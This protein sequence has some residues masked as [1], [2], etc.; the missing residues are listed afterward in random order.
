[1]AHGRFLAAHLEWPPR[2]RGNQYLADLAGLAFA[3]AYRPSG[4]EADLWLA[5]AA[6]QLAAEIPR[7]FGPDGGGFEAS[8]LYHR[9]SA[10]LALYPAALL[11]GLPEARGQA[12]AAL[13]AKRWRRRPPLDTAP[14]PWPPLGPRALGRLAAAIRF[15]ADV[16]KPSG[17]AA[18][19]GDTDSGRLFKLAPAFDLDGAAPLERDLDLGGLLAAGAGLFDPDRPPPAWAA[20]ETRIVAALAGG[21]RP[22]LE[23]PAPPP[24]PLAGEPPP[25]RPAERVVRLRLRLPD[26]TA[27]DGRLALAYPD[28]GL[29]LWRGPRLF[30]ALRCGAV[31]RDGTGGHA[32]ND[33]L[34]VELEVD[35]VPWARDPGTGCY[36][37]D[38]ALRDRYRSVLAHFAP[39]DGAAEPGRLDLG[40]FRLEDHADARLASFDATAIV[41]WHRGFGRPVV[42]HLRVEGAELLVEDR[43]GGDRVGPATR[44][45]THV[46][47]SPA[48]LVAL[49][50]LDLPF[51][52]G[53][54]RFST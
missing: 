17:Q 31:G 47:E 41:A 53:Y 29:Y 50:G 40:P 49:W 18:Q 24:H 5:F 9:L 33:Q 21:R 51:S 26:P 8:T 19:I 28:F 52:P 23:R 6:A 15:A 27:L 37:P 54:G 36:T 1:M 43:L 35:G 12:A 32:H 3:A 34:G 42:R 38:L 48:A 2:R 25:D 11:L 20:V 30:L 7:Q 45:E 13:P 4:D 39:R 46:I 44:I 22:A 14:R 10:E 16:T